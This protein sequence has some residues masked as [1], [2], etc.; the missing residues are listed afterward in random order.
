MFLLLSTTTGDIRGHFRLTTATRGTAS[1]LGEVTDLE[2]ILGGSADDVL[3]GSGAANL[4]TGNDGDDVL[5]GTDG[6]DA[7]DG[8]PGVDTLSGGDD[9]DTIT[10]TDGVRDE[11][12]CGDGTDTVAADDVDDV[13]RD[14]ENVARTASQPAPPATPSG[15]TLVERP[16]TA[17]L[18][19]VTFAD[20]FLQ[21]AD[22]Q[23]HQVRRPGV[24]RAQRR[25]AHARR[26]L[27]VG[28]GVPV[29]VRPPRR[30]GHAVGAR[31]RG[32]HR[33]GPAVT[34]RAAQARPRPPAPPGGDP[35]H[36][37]DRQL[38][39]RAPADDG[40]HARR[41]KAQAEA[42]VAARSANGSFIP[43]ASARTAAPT[44]A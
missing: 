40:A 44:E 14:C 13:D 7:L 36:P 42:E 35:D 19:D 9:D 38:G 26:R 11:I 4:L 22:R 33:D 41:A 34:R 20:V 10:G 28:H 43:T 12:R 15:P 3:V 24:R 17:A 29:R 1:G 37:R 8:G 30:E 27:P 21:I 32:A 39:S 25:G 2:N 18:T 5:A 23:G 16:V 31:R 6:A